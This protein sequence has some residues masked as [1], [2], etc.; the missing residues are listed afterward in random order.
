MCWNFVHAFARL[1]VQ[2]GI[3]QISPLRFNSLACKDCGVDL[4]PPGHQILQ[5]AVVI[6]PFLFSEEVLYT[7]K[8]FW[9]KLLGRRG[10]LIS[11]SMKNSVHEIPCPFI[12]CSKIS[13][14]RNA[15]RHLLC[16][17]KG[18]GHCSI[19]KNQCIMKVWCGI[20]AEC[21]DLE[22]ATKAAS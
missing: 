15:W 16:M 3:Q 18:S 22:D 9:L 5:S 4:S 12:L 17:M 2:I 21:I 1:K 11:R 13:F 14:F 10:L 8:I 6:I 19:Y 7:F 20:L